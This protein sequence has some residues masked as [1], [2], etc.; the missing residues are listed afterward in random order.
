MDVE[1]IDWPDK[2]Q[3]PPDATKNIIHGEVSS[4]YQ[5]L[6]LIKGK[7]LLLNYP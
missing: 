3:N 2:T 4:D 7:K 6:Y 1:K 5:L